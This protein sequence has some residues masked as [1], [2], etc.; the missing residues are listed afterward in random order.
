MRYLYLVIHY[1]KPEHVEDLLTEMRRLDET[2]RGTPGL[3]QIGPW[4]EEQ[5]GRIVAL[6][7]WESREAFAAAVGQIAAAVADVPFDDWEERPPEI[8]QAEEIMLHG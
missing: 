6:S 5:T 3:L 1:P 2:M 7:L 8:L 4:R